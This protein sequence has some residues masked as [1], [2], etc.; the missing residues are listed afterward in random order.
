[1]KMLIAYATKTGAAAQCAKR[2]AALLP[3]AVVCDLSRETPA[4]SDYDAVIVGGGV[5]MGR[6]YR[7]ARDFLRANEGALLQKRRGL[8]LCSGFPDQAKDALSQNV[9]AAL[10]AH[11]VYADSL[12]GELDAQKLRGM[13]RL[14][15]AMAQKSRPDAPPP[16]ILD[17]R[18]EELAAT[19]R[20]NAD[21]A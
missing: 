13:S 17:A 12:G 19:M 15:A 14:I 16:R 11:A 4:L 3:G 9:P 18:V 20:G 1:M 5:R 6:L 7:A 10:L 8:F 2:L 21:D